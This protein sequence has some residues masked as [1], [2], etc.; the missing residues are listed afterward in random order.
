[1]PTVSAPP[2]RLS[3]ITAWPRAFAISGATRRAMLSVAL[4]VACGTTRRIGRSGHSAR[5]APAATRNSRGNHRLM[6]SRNATG[7]RL[8]LG[9]DLAALVRGAVDVHV[10]LAVLE[11]LHLLW[12]ELLALGHGVGVAL[13]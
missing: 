11:R 2:G 8:E 12:R 4:P 10:Q 5:A 3:T 13:L 6:A 9:A 7:L 1:M